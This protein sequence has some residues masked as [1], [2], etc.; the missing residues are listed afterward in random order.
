MAA[1]DVPSVDQSLN[2][3]SKSN[4]RLEKAKRDERE[5]VWWCA[6]RRYQFTQLAASRKVQIAPTSSPLLQRIHARSQ[7]LGRAKKR[8]GSAEAGRKGGKNKQATRTSPPS[9]GVRFVGQGARH[10]YPNAFDAPPHAT[11]PASG[12]T[13]HLWLVTAMKLGSFW[14]FRS[15]ERKS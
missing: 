12:T 5:R 9:V 11:Q 14:V 6:R 15:K 7:R 4:D 13:P 1:A 2:A 10:H 3:R 8:K